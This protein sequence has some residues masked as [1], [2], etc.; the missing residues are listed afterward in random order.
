MGF[1]FDMFGYRMFFVS[2]VSALWCLVYSLIGYTT[3]NALGVMVISSL[4]AAFNALPFL[5]S[6]PLIV[7]RQ[8]ELGLALGVWKVR[9]F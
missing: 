5:A 2:F 4:A 9:L 3:V 1:F 6:I 7:N 8:T